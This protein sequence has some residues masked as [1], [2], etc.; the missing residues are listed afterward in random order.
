MSLRLNALQGVVEKERFLDYAEQEQLLAFL[1]VKRNLILQG[2]PGTG[3]NPSREALPYAR[4]G[5][6]TIEEP[7][8]H[9]W[10]SAL[11]AHRAEEPGSDQSPSI[12]ISPTRIS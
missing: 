11:C 6:N 9:E 12:R 8:M 5:Q 3:P 4:I 1:R 7:Y 2:A 10:I